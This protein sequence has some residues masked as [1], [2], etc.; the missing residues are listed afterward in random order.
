MHDGKALIGWGMATATYPTNRSPS[1]AAA[2]L[3]PDGRAIVTAAA[4]DLGTGTYT[5]L[6][7][8]AAQV[9]GLP[10]DRVRVILGDT[11]LPKAPVAGG[12]QTAAS[13][14]SAVKAAAEQLVHNL[15][16]FAVN[17]PKSPL[18]GRDPIQIVAREGRLVHEAQVSR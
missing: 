2:R 13:V 4:H 14:G 10:P 6:T 5:I 11:S 16:H 17:D 7:Q 18:A 9:L 12:S 1:T 15:A 8:I 3:M